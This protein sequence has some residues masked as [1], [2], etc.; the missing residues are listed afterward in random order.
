MLFGSKGTELTALTIIEE[1]QI[2]TMAPPPFNRT[3]RMRERNL[4]YL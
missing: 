3:D 2:A 1:I 4:D